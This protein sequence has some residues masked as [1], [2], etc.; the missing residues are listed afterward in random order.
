MHCEYGKLRISNK[1]RIIVSVVNNGKSV[2]ASDHY[3]IV[4]ATQLTHNNLTL[5]S[6]MV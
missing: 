1:S 5:A 2:S 6:E 3:S 4:L